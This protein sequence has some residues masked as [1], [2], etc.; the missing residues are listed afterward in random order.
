MLQLEQKWGVDQLNVI[1]PSCTASTEFARRWVIP[2]A[3]WRSSAFLDLAGGNPADHDGGAPSI[4]W[5]RI[6]RW[7][8]PVPLISHGLADRAG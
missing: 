5:G 3:R 7:F 8:S 2:V 4:P 6:D 1:R